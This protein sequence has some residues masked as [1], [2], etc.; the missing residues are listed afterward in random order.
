MNNFDKEMNIE[1][2]I[3]YIKDSA[4]EHRVREILLRKIIREGLKNE[5]RNK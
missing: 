3:R 4:Y 5:K 2:K 1:E